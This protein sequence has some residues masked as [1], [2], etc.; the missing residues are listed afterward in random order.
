MYIAT[1]R[2]IA[3]SITTQLLV[4]DVIYYQKTKKYLK[5]PKAIL[6]WGVKASGLRAERLA[7]E[8]SVECWHLEDG[9]IRSYLP[10]AKAVGLSLIVDKVGIYY[11]ATRPSD[12]EDLLESP[13]NVLH[14]INV[15]VNHVMQLIKKNKI[16]KYNHVPDI[17]EN[18]LGK[19]QK[20]GV[21]V[22]DQTYGDLSV[23]KGG[24]SVADFQKMVKV[25]LDENPESVIYIKTH[26]EVSSGQKRGY[27]SDFPDHPR[28][29]KIT[30]PCNPVSLLRY[31]VKVYVV[32]STM[33][34][35]AL[36]LNKPVT[37]FGMPWYAGW[38]VTD[39]RQH[40]ARRT[41]HRSVKEL[42]AAAYIHY[43]KY[44][45]PFTHKAGNIVDVVNWLILQ[46]EQE[47]TLPGRRIAVGLRK[48][49]AANLAPLLSLNPE[50]LI[51]AKSAHELNK[52]NISKNDQV[53]VWGRDMSSEIQ[54]IVSRSGARHWRI[55]DGFIRSVGLG[56]N[57]VA[58]LSLVIDDN[59]I[60]FD[61]STPSRLE[62]ILASL[63]CT[64]EELQRA[65]R[66]REII[67]RQ[68]ITK[69]NIEPKSIPHWVDN[70]KQ[71]VLVPGQVEDDA[72]ICYGSKTISSNE[73]LLKAARQSHPQALIVYK[74][75]PDVVF[76]NRAG[77]VDRT[78][79]YADVVETSC[80]VIS[81]IE[82]CDIV[83]TM[84]S[85]VG[86]DALLRDKKV[87]TYGEPFYAGWGLTE[88]RAVNSQALK[89]RIRELSLSELM[90]GVLLRY[91]RYWDPALKGFTTCES[92][93]RQIVHKRNEIDASN[94]K[95]ENKVS[96][97][98]KQLIKRRAIKQARFNSY[99]I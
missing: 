8:Y 46:K 60:Y 12:L 49:K 34:F 57:M 55:E 67:V 89:R 44:L 68:G 97:F 21:L 59:G 13:Q 52:L 50:Q 54:S 87:V 80:S 6:G 23:S 64:S 18:V 16:S 11:D 9:F 99:K 1:S 69:Y 22:I 77:A 35:E 37:V 56:A 7:S 43:T 78:K 84:T 30:T 31:V 39:D 25:A 51:F 86:F 96:F 85:L 45:N 79:H 4:D 47:A 72:S 62:L 36:M 95:L 66:I 5:Q 29:V 27:L 48:W 33:G 65:R 42:F 24:A 76:A 41:N 82:H 73:A 61:P 15:N 40:C 70:E 88:D 93:I 63:E 14:N 38:G 32:T 74:P 90:I 53:L 28:V 2:P 17:D 71:V 10:G 81:C 83:H 19:S 91:P 3:S 92:V 26:P 98:K 75:H 94:V 58:P 20:D